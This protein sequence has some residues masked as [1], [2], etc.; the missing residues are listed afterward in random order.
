M[1]NLLDKL[2]N[3]SKKTKI[4]L[5]S[6][7]AAVLVCAVVITVVI[8][9][10]VNKEDTDGP[11]S[12]SDSSSTDVSDS[13]E[14]DDLPPEPTFEIDMTQYK[15]IYDD[16]ADARFNEAVA[17]F[18]KTMSDTIGYEVDVDVDNEWNT[19]QDK[20]L[21]IGLSNR[22]ESQASLDRTK[23]EFAFNISL[24]GDKICVSGPTLGVIKE[25]L[26]FLQENYIAKS[27]GGGKFPLAE[28]MNYTSQELPNVTVIDE[29]KSCLFDV[30]YPRS[31]TVGTPI[32]AAAMDLVSF[33]QEYTV[34]GQEVESSGDFAPPGGEFDLTKYSFVFGNTD[35]PRSAEIAE[36]LSYFGW[37][38]EYLDHQMYLFSQDAASSTVLLAELKEIL[39][40]GIYLDGEN[41]AMRIVIPE[42]K[43]GYFAD[44]C[45][46]I[47]EYVPVEADKGKVTMDTI[48][49]F[50][51]G[52][53][54]IFLNDV[55][56]E[57]YASYAKLLT[58]S[59]YTVYQT[60]SVVNGSRTNYFTTYVGKDSV[61]HIYYLAYQKDLRI[62]VGDKDDFVSYNTTATAFT[63]AQKVASPS[64]TIMDMD[65]FNQ[66]AQDNGQG[67]I[68]T[69]ADGSYV[70]M[71]GGYNANDADKLY[72]FLVDNNKRTDGK[73]LIRAWFI[74]HPHEDHYGAY[75]AFAASYARNVTLENA[76]YQFDYEG[77]MNPDSSVGGDF[78]NNLKS[79]LAEISSATMKFMGTKVITPF[80]GQTL[81]FGDLGVEIIATSEML[82]PNQVSDQNEHSMITRLHFAGN[83]V[84][85]MGDVMNPSMQMKTIEK[86]YGSYL[87]STFITAPHHG[88]NGSDALYAVVRPE[89][90]IFHTNKEHYEERIAHGGTGPACNYQLVLNMNLPDGDPNKYVKEMF[91][92]EKGEYDG[93][94]ILYFPFMGSDW[95][96]SNFSDG[97]YNG[98]QLDQD[99]WGSL[100]Q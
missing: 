91:F 69:L 96:D 85:N 2:K 8:I 46:E 77:A 15:V 18:V 76:V 14:G 51:E 1:K 43:T 37:Q 35:Y 67:L 38:M 61:V 64:M 92:A 83:T 86:A 20:E 34:E 26:D 6:A 80:A 97:D 100:P 53:Y 95:Y 89:Y 66:A 59:G 57:G 84:L 49:E 48:T 45:V 93:Y 3:L 50:S 68:F 10:N 36:N 24:L 79:T 65:Y 13:G 16:K 88:L 81:Y 71:D 54:R 4:I 30:V 29:N 70:I 56:P 47:P 58:S 62:L 94:Q 9:I 7:I 99:N 72:K 22:E 73:V 52:F 40:D 11:G 87:Q 5:L 19:P 90:V 32:S 28:N 41:K 63:A 33:L 82:Y 31:A 39:L 98:G 25:G 60:K 23:G 12:E 74:S 78:A 42:A 44:W 27:Q 75:V 17:A 21:L 55:S